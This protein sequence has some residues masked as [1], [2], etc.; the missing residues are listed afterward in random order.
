MWPLMCRGDEEGGEEGG[1]TYGAVGHCIETVDWAT[2]I[3]KMHAI[4]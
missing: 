2:S 3:S 4:L 1:R